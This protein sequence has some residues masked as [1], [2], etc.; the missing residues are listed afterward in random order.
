[1]STFFLRFALAA[2]VATSA[3]ALYDAAHHGLTGQYSQFSA[4][5]AYPNVALLSDVIHGLNYAALAAIMILVSREIG[6]GRWRRGIGWSLAVLF[7]IFAVMHLLASPVAAAT[8]VE[9]ELLSDVGGILS[10]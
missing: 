9:I 6:A 1:M 7:G 8:G 2:A 4:D 5:S 10:C 3:I